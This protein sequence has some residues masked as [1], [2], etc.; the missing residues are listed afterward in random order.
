MQ[1]RNMAIALAVVLL[2]IQLLALVAGAAMLGMMGSGM[3][4]NMM[5]MLMGFSPF[6]GIVMLLLPG[7]LVGVGLILL[8]IWL[9]R[10]GSRSESDGTRALDIL[11]ERYARGELN[12]EQ[13]EQM[14]NQI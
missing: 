4:S 9:A 2:V 7:A 8:I 14:R 11:R 6:G 3:M 1:T 10:Q 13:Y 12:Q 5:G